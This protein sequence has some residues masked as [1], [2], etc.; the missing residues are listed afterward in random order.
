MSVTDMSHGAIGETLIGNLI[1][2]LSTPRNMGI[3][4]KD[5]NCVGAHAC[6]SFDPVLPQV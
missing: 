1:Q 5:L 3:R 4:V 2:M 6:L